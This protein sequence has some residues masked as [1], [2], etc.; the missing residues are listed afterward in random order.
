MNLDTHLGLQQC[1]PYPA[2]TIMKRTEIIKLYSSPPIH[3][4]YVFYINAGHFS[5]QVCMYVWPPFSSWKLVLKTKMA[6]TYYVSTVLIYKMVNG[7]VGGILIPLHPIWS[8]DDDLWKHSLSH[9]IYKKKTWYDWN[10]DCSS[11]MGHEFAQLIISRHVWTTNAPSG[12]SGVK[13]RESSISKIYPHEQM[14]FNNHQMFGVRPSHKK[15]FQWFK[16]SWGARWGVWEMYRLWVKNLFALHAKIPSNF[17]VPLQLSLF[18]QLWVSLSWVN[19]VH[20]EYKKPS[21][22][23]LCYLGFWD[24]ITNNSP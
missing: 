10:Y 9:I 17:S 6:Q 2:L 11:W 7:V 21:S 22:I 18:N 13:V 24:L 14:N 15:S 5:I 1:F 23:G 3:W 19:F 16:R 4:K 8:C 12:G 20:G